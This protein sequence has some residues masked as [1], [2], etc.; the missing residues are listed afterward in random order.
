MSIRY[1]EFIYAI[2]YIGN[3]Y[4]NMEWERNVQLFGEGF[5]SVMN[6]KIERLWV[7]RAFRVDM[8]NYI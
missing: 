1:V 2:F 7:C 5:E 6:E 4:R 3:E 8:Y